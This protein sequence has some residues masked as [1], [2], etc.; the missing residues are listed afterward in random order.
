MIEKTSSKDSLASF[1]GQFCHDGISRV[2]VPIGLRDRRGFRGHG[3][4]TEG[5]EPPGG[6]A[7]SLG[8]QAGQEGKAGMIHHMKENMGGEHQAVLS[9]PKNIYMILFHEYHFIF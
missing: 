2:P 4:G 8:G 5:P 6:Q 9:T 1:S 3:Q 7:R